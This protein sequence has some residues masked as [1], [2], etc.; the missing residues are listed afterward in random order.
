MCQNDPANQKGGIT[1]GN[2]FRV[3]LLEL[4][5]YFLVTLRHLTKPL[6][7]FDFVSE[8]QFP[9]SGAIF[10][11]FI[12]RDTRLKKSQASIAAVL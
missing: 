1:S 9:T 2:T 8:T 6:S 4:E 3:I 11:H 10:F 12:P 7:K 5:L